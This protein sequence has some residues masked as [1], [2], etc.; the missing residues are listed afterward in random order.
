MRSATWS[1]DRPS[2]PI[3]ETIQIY[4]LCFPLWFL[5]WCSSNTHSFFSD[6]PAFAPQTQIGIELFKLM[7]VWI[8]YITSWPCPPFAPI[9]IAKRKLHHPS[10][11]TQSQSVIPLKNVRLYALVMSHTSGMQRSLW[12]RSCTSLDNNGQQV[13]NTI[14]SILD[15]AL[16]RNRH[17]RS[18]SL[19]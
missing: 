11:T 5:C 17:G 15:F 2:N 13:Q 9:I 16:L 10:S 7:V 19:T 4:V 1:E 18:S 14:P 3:H 8:A 6:G 12:P